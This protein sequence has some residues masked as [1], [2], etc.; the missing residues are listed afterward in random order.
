MTVFGVL[1]IPVM[2][3]SNGGEIFKYSTVITGYLAS[4]TCAMFSLAMFWGR[5]TEAV[6]S[7]M[8]MDSVLQHFWGFVFW[9]LLTPRN[10]AFLSVNRDLSR[11][12]HIVR[13][14]E[15]DTKHRSQRTAKWWTDSLLLPARYIFLHA[16]FFSSPDFLLWSWLQSQ[17]CSFR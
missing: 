12:R 2:A 13:I 7:N 11:Y 6:K 3:S 16:F 8:T 9:F 1:L 14:L 4:P 5:T 15:A 17:F 10:T